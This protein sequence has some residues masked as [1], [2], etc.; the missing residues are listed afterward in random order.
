ML[1][2]IS[3]A[4]LGLQCKT[5]VLV[6]P[7]LFAS[8]ESLKFRSFVFSLQTSFSLKIILDLKKRGP[9]IILGQKKILVLKKIKVQK[10]FVYEKNCVSK[11]LFG[12]EKKFGTKKNVVPEKFWSE[13]I[14][15][16]I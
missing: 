2:L 16:K 11:K 14:W 8:L 12:Y 7:L 10:N 5:L 13:K 3:L 6:K 4:R 9:N 1:Q 15:I